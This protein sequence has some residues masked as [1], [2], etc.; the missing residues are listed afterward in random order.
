MG[1][2]GMWVRRNGPFL[3]VSAVCV[4]LIV[5]DWRAAPPPSIEVHYAPDEDLERIDVAAIGE[6]RERIDFAAYVLSD[7]AVVEAL[8]EAGR[9]GVA[10][11]LLRD[12][13]AADQTGSADVAALET[14]PNVTVRI[15]PPGPLMHL[16][17]YAIDR[18]L[19]RLGS[20]NFSRSGETRQANDLELMRD[21]R[22]AA[23]FEATFD[24]A[25][26]AAE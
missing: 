23:R 17:A 4:G 8:K 5:N 12:L 18:R 13:S 21:A 22:E 2:A 15:S 7:R 11:R 3:L 9:R 26:R 16:K 19:L 24:R 20:A 14:A 1:T 25:W 6:A 10:I